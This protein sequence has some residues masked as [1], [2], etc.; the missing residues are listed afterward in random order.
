[1]ERLRHGLKKGLKPAQILVLGFAG[2]ILLGTFLLMLPISSVNGQSTSFINSIFTSTSAVCVTGLVVVDTG[3]YWSVFGKTVILLLIQIGGLG[4]MTMATS[5]AIILGKKISLRNR[6]IMQEALNQFSISGVIRLTLYIVLTTLGIEFI[7]AL[8]LS[9]RFIPQFGPKN[10]FYYAVFHSVSAF[11]NA[12]FDIMGNG[13]SLTQYVSDPL[14]SIVIILLI[15]LGGLGFSVIVDIGGV[16][17]AKKLSLHSKLA[18]TMTGSLIFSGFVI[19]MLFEMNN[20]NTIG[21]LSFGGKILGALFHSITPRTAGF[22]TLDM[23]QLKLPTL[24]FTI[25]FMFVGGS[26][27]STAGG[28]KTTTIG[29]IFLKVKSV[30]KGVDDVEFAH[31]RISKEIINRALAVFFIASFVFISV[32]IL[33]TIT[34]RDVSLEYVLFEAMSALGTVGLSLGLTPHLS[35]AGKI[36][37]AATMFFGRLGPLTIVLALSNRNLSKR[38]AIRYPEGKIIVG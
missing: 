8:F 27:G 26:P 38:K 3:T 31:R 1:M 33:L 20:P 5:I 17:N 7:G 14:V 36:I 19:V 25:L 30:I 22:N 6:L 24:I 12:G 16:K 4:F 34:E 11:C 13:V 29:V 2:T 35:F 9:I 23:A 10:G 28:V 21:N 15:V 32:T 18:L 37:I